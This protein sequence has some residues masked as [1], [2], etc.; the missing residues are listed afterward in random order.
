M[1]EKQETKKQEEEKITVKYVG[2]TPE[3]VVPGFFDGKGYYKKKGSQHTFSD[4]EDIEMAKQLVE[5]NP[6]FKEVER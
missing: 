2:D 4:P 3:I 6:N 5:S 1:A